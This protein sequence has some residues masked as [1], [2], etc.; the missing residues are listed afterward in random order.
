MDEFLNGG[1][2]KFCSCFSTATTGF[3]LQD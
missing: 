1:L 3:V 2:R